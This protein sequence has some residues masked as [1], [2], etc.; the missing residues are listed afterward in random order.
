MKDQP[1]DI[2]KALHQTATA[3]QE[4]TRKMDVVGWQP[5]NAGLRPWLRES[6]PR[7]IRKLCLISTLAGAGIFSVQAAVDLTI[8]GM[9]ITQGVQTPGNT[10]QLVAQRSTAVRVTIGVS[11]SAVPVANVTGQLHVLL[12]GMDIAAPFSPINAPFTAPLA[13]QRGNQND[14]LNFELPNSAL[15]PGLPGLD[16]RI[17]VTPVPG[18]A[19]TANNSLTVPNL[20]FVDHSIPIIFFAKINYAGHGF[21]SDSL[22]DPEVGDE[23]FRG[24]Y[25]VKDLDDTL[26]GLYQ[27]SGFAPSLG[28]PVY[29]ANN[30]GIVDG[31]DADNLLD[32]LASCRHALLTSPFHPGLAAISDR[33]YLYGWLNGNPIDGNGVSKPG[34]NVAFGNTDPTR[35]QR[36]FAHEMGH[37]FGFSHNNLNID[38]VDWDVGGRL[39][40]D[41]A[42]NNIPVGDPAQGRIKPLTFFDIMFPARLTDE[43]WITSANYTAI[44]NHPALNAP[45]P[46]AVTNLFSTNVL[47][48]RGVFN[49]S[50]S[51]LLRLGPFF[52]YPWLTAPPLSN[53]FAGSQFQARVIDS[54]GVVTLAPFSALRV[55]DTT[56][57]NPV[58][59]F[60]EVMVAVPAGRAATNVEITDLSG[61]TNFGSLARSVVKPTVQILAPTNNAQLGSNTFV[62]FFVSDTDT[63][64][65][66]RQYQVVYSANDGN[67]WVPV[68]IN[69]PGPNTFIVFDSTQIPETRE[70]GRLRV[71]ASDGL[72]TSYADISGLTT[73]ASS[74]PNPDDPRLAITKS[75]NQAVVSWPAN[76]VGFRLQ[77]SGNLMS[78]AYSTNPVPL[79]AKGRFTV[80]VFGSSN[81]FYRLSKK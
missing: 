31:P 74:V 62:S 45:A 78:W 64:A 30:N 63:P 14:T 44:A 57:A 41:P 8:T 73:T 1:S 42:G 56:N 65:T 72:N 53:N 48:I 67:S 3:T 39:I 71:I 27:Y 5:H 52:T 80:P 17:D 7:S 61:T 46:D 12:G 6:R 59:G 58:F 19:N 36:T 69:V 43:A 28:P 33:V 22:I 55:E 29:D 81:I 77:K 10:I 4:T 11:G 50:G 35:H 54:A 23:M 25:P 68:G 51:Q 15:P 21:P 16:F 13:P 18:E 9:E 75:N 20:T 38:Q 47:V 24:I 79:V 32:Y 40:N 66:N 60:F 70:K 34:A 49:G 37:L 2:S 76:A 26:T